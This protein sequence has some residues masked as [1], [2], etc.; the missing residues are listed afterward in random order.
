MTVGSVEINKP[1]GDR[2]SSSS[3]PTGDPNGQNDPNPRAHLTGVANPVN[4]ANPVRRPAP[5]GNGP[6]CRASRARPTSWSSRPP[7]RSA[8]TTLDVEIDYTGTPGV[9][10]DGDGTNEGWFKN[11]G[12]GGFVTA[13]RGRHRGLAAARRDADAKPTTTTR[14]TSA[15]PASATAAWSATSTTRPATRT[16]RT[17]TRSGL[18][19]G[20]AGGELLVEDS[21]G[22]FDL[23]SRVAGSGVIYYEAQ[24]SAIPAAKKTTNTAV[25]D[26]QES[27]V[28]LSPSSMDRGRSPPTA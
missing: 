2:S 22:S 21:I 27:I 23:S 17:A 10:D 14:P 8:G 18:D 4:A 15:R 7:R 3:R 24:G 1:A 20:R 26:T 11:P 25:M 28:N 5:A 6:R 13:E 16:S 12:D 19:L 9:H